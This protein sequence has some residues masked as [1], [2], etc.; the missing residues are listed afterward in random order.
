MLKS[1]SAFQ[2]ILKSLYYPLISVLLAIGCWVC[3]WWIQIELSKVYSGLFF[4]T[5]VYL[6]FYYLFV[7]I[8]KKHSEK[9]GF[10][11]LILMTLKLCFIFGYLFLFLNPSASENKREVLLFLMNYFALLIVDLTLKVRVMK[12]DK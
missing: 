7:L 6:L 11:F 2:V 9:G 1:N 3:N 12:Q 10:I 5:G 8:Q 4:L